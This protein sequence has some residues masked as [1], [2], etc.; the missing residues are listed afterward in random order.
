MKF[1]GHV[2]MS[3]GDGLC[4]ITVSKVPSNADQTQS[5]MSSKHV[6]APC[7]C[8]VWDSLTVLKS[9]THWDL[10]THYRTT[11]IVRDRNFRAIVLDRQEVERWGSPSNKSEMKMAEREV[12]MNVQQ[13]VTSES[14]L[15]FHIDKQ[16]PAKICALP[17]SD[18]VSRAD[19]SDAWTL[20][21][22]QYPLY[23]TRLLHWD[24]LR[25]GSSSY[26]VDQDIYQ[27]HLAN[28]ATLAPTRGK[29]KSIRSSCLLLP[30]HSGIA[31]NL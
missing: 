3:W 11:R 24:I 13:G 28:I 4:L 18:S 29:N 19:F 20:Q 23:F 30:H 17:W 27:L 14:R 8:I 26:N 31:T 9:Y 12:Q 1:S 2:G 15:F 21:W 7:P 16:P 6:W 22:R 5:L 10:A 25:V